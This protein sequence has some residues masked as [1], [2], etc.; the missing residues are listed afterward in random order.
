MQDFIDAAGRPPY[1]FLFMFFRIIMETRDPKELFGNIHNG[2]I[3]PIRIRV[4][5]SAGRAIFGLIVLVYVSLWKVE[6]WQRGLAGVVWDRSQFSRRTA[7]RSMLILVATRRGEWRQRAA[8]GSRVFR[9][10]RPGSVRC[11][12]FVDRP[13]SKSL[14]RSANSSA[15]SSSMDDLSPRHANVIQFRCVS[16]KPFS[17]KTLETPSSTGCGVPAS[18]HGEKLSVSRPSFALRQRAFER[19]NKLNGVA[20]AR[21]A[22]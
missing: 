12:Q 6:A 16:G 21:V 2:V 22:A 9:Y 7:L 4:Q 13:I 5:S 14:R 1:N 18:L 15:S 8:C 17:I 19:F 10:F 20:N 11:T 3:F